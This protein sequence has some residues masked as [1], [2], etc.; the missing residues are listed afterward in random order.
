MTTR[1]SICNR[2]LS[3]LGIAKTISDLD[4]DGTAE[5]IALLQFYEPSVRQ[6]LRDFAWP[7]A[8]AFATLDLVE[9]DPTVEWDYSYRL[10]SDCLTVRRIVQPDSS[11]NETRQ[12]RAPWRI[13]RDAASTAWDSG[14]TYAVGEYVSAT[15]DGARVWYVCIQAGTNQNPTTQT[16]YWTALTGAPPKLL[17]TDKVDAQIEYTAYVDDILEYEEDF[18]EALAARLAAM[19]APRLT[20]DETGKTAQRPLQLYSWLISRAQ[21]NAANEEQPDDPQPSEFE[22]ARNM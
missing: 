3:H 17:L 22:R 15:V 1:E 19:A 5:S 4:A 9:E 20:Q 14:T 10:P 7:F 12:S 6:V 8:T 2:A 11:R 21:A 13:V 16:A 18:I